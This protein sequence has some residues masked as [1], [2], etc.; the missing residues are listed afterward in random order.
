MKGIRL[1]TVAGASAVLYTPLIVTFLLLSSP[2]ALG[3]DAT[4]VLRFMAEHRTR[5]I[6]ALLGL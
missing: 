2:D 5:A 4:D 1:A 3:G 6:I